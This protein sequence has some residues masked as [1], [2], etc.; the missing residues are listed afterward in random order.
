MSTDAKKTEWEAKFTA[1][2]FTLRVALYV[3]AVGLI[4][5]LGYLQIDQ[6]HIYAAKAEQNRLREIPVKAQ[7]GAVYGRTRDV[8]LV[9]NRA[10]FD[11]FI[12]PKDCEGR[13]EEVCGRLESVTGID[14]ESLL[15][16]ICA[17]RKR[18]FQQ[19]PVKRDI[20]QTELRQVE[21]LSSMLPGVFVLPRPQRRYL[22]GETAGQIMGWLNEVSKDELKQWPEYRMGDVIGRGGLE[23]QYD[24][25]L[26][27]RD[28]RMVVTLFNLGEPQL[29]TDAFGTPQT[30][31]DQLGRVV[32]VEYSIPAVSGRSIS[33]TL[34][35]ALQEKAEKLLAGIPVV[36]QIDSATG[37]VYYEPPRG[38]I[39]VLNADTGEV[40]ALA[41]VPGYDPNLF[42]EKQGAR[43][44]MTGL[45]PRARLLRDRRLRPMRHRAY[46]EH[47][48]PGS[49]FKVAMAVAALEEGVITPKTTFVCP[50]HFYLGRSRWGCWRPN[51]HGAVNVVQALTVSCDVFFYNVG[52]NLG[53]D[54]IKYW[55]S[56]LGLGEM[57]GI[58]LPG[59]VSGLVPS[60]EWK[61]TAPEFAHLDRWNRR[62][63]AGETINV[64]IGQGHCALTPVQLA[65]MTAAIVNG[66]R[67]VTPYVNLDKPPEISEPLIQERTLEVVREG[68]RQCIVKQDYPSGTGRLAHIE[69]MDVIGKTGTAQIVS[70]SF[71]EKDE[72]LIP[73]FK[74]AH[75]WFV[76][77]VL[78]REPRIAVCVLY[79]HGLHGSRGAAP[80]A[81]ELIEFFYRE[82]A[83][84]LMLVAKTE[85]RP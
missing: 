82:R 42:V 45:S 35:V 5:R 53:I 72:H 12:V 4:L 19:I 51:G 77:G 44:D 63:Q 14:S 47:Y 29:R 20:S 38:A 7:R 55:S 37:E 68:M 59:E 58:D 41:S 49:V 23:K 6:G 83:E 60:P 79:E 50:G 52:R 57:T 17:L 16:E 40:Y 64:A 31:W 34:D 22:L 21:E 11:L 56:K 61:E 13:E 25:T 32:P 10:A 65:V 80:L 30:M 2:V 48:P 18:P 70:E 54:R 67:R 3:L 73:Y 46:Q 39:V 76:A 81:K 8:V 74:R 15:T 1:R 26:R 62:W 85:E 24:S 69:G 84:G 43:P 28:G 36:E 27:G 66:G 71:S 9:G 75:A 33:V 78:D